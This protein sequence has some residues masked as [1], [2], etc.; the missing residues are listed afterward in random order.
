MGCNYSRPGDD[1]IVKKFKARKCFM[2]QAVSQRQAFSAAHM[3]YLQALRNTGSA[4]RQF[5]EGEAKDTMSSATPRS[6]LELPPPPPPHLISSPPSKLSIKA[7]DI[8]SSSPKERE[9]SK[10]SWSPGSS[11]SEKE[12]DTPPPPSPQK[13]T[14]DIFNPFR[15]S[16]PPFNL[17]SESQHRRKGRRGAQEQHRSR[18]MYSTGYEDEGTGSMTVP[19]LEDEFDGQRNSVLA[20]WERSNRDF[21]TMVRNGGGERD[22]LDMVKE[23]DTR[24]LQASACGTAVS[25]VLETR[26]GH[27]LSEVADA[28]KTA[29]SGSM[30]SPRRWNW[31][32]SPQASLDESLSSVAESELMGSHALTLERLRVWEKKLFREVKAAESLRSEYQKKCYLLRQ[33]EAKGEDASI[34]DKTRSAMKRD[35]SQMLVAC[36]G[37]ES[38][39]AAIRKVRDEELYPQLVELSQG[40]MYMWRTMHE[41]HVLQKQVVLQFKSLESTWATH[42][43]TSQYHHHA[44][45]VLEKEL[46][47]WHECFC[48]LVCSHREYITALNGWAHLSLLHIGD[49]DDLPNKENL[50]VIANEYFSAPSPSP[51]KLPTPPTVS[52]CEEWQKALDRLPDKVASEAIKSLVAVV[53]ALVTQQSDELKQK[54]KVERL[55]KKLD[56]KTESLHIAERKQVEAAAR[57]PPIVSTKKLDVDEFEDESMS[58]DSERASDEYPTSGLAVLAKD[59][60]TEKKAAVEALRKK[61]ENERVKHNKCVADTRMLTMNNLQTGLPGVFEAMTGFSAVCGQAFQALCN[62]AGQQAAD[63]F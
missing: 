40:L 8:E 48:K 23:L 7:T 18:G 30:F 20:K 47:S 51:R 31:S 10:D 45:A 32:K 6:P 26:K 3:C 21:A 37:I 11:A 63:Q 62:H 58:T 1:D 59:P 34:V 46:N 60:L 28:K 16:S 57:T 52:L 35:H 29:N 36:Q 25:K 50:H 14:W 54:R 9:K 41:C 15:P 42:E 44:T 53:H 4:L 39:S 61:L 19:R 24:F 2:K 22:L 17:Q 43:A 56:K 13:S 49:V 55:S 27:F 38:T 12:S 5:S 33:Q